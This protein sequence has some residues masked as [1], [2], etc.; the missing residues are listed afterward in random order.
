M[1]PQNLK[2]RKTAKAYQRLKASIGSS[3]PL[4]PLETATDNN[5]PTSA[6]HAL[7]IGALESSWVIPHTSV[8]SNT[9]NTPALIS[10]HYCKQEPARD[11]TRNQTVTSTFVKHFPFKAFL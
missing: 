2:F 5:Y 7:I 9:K 4:P 10:K 8:S 11:V 3:F 1:C 6:N